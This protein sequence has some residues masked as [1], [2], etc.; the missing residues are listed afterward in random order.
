MD[1][2]Y[3]YCSSD[4]FEKIISSKS[5]RLCS[6]LLSNDYK[7]GNAVI[8]LI[9]VLLNSK[10]YS[11]EDRKNI[12]EWLSFF[13]SHFHGIGFCLSENGD[14]LSQWRGYANDGAGFSIGFSK[15]V[16]QKISNSSKTIGSRDVSLIKVNYETISHLPIVSPT[17][18]RLKEICTNPEYKTT[19]A[20]LL[21]LLPQD[22]LAEMQKRK[23]DS[24]ESKLLEALLPISD[25]LYTLKNYAF[26]E[27]KEWRLVS[28]IDGNEFSN[29]ECHAKENKLIPYDTIDLTSYSS[30]VIR[31]VTVGPKNQTPYSVIRNWLK[32]KG[33]GEVEVKNSIASY[34]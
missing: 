7:E 2:L 13:K 26:S 6:L 34:R 22:D 30:T 33:Y 28:R 5:I 17:I 3:H 11:D 12:S 20:G 10:E 16:L 4:S 24:K 21:S 9:E 23:R 1:T 32:E 19:L 15:N 31:T 25:I 27:E 14:L 29:I 18:K 8:E